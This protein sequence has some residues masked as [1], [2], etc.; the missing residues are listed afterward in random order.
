[1]T[2]VRLVTVAS[3]T[4]T[5]AS[6]SGS[7]VYL[8][9]SDVVKS[10]LLEAT[11]SQLVTLSGPRDW[12]PLSSSTSPTLT[13]AIRIAALCN[14]ARFQSKAA[15]RR[16]SRDTTASEPIDGPATATT[17]SLDEE[18]ALEAEEKR[19]IVGGNGIDKALLAWAATHGDPATTRAQHVQL[20]DVPFSSA[21]KISAGVWESDTS[22]FVAVK[23]APEF[24]LDRCASALD[25]NGNVVPMTSQ[26]FASITAAID[27]LSRKGQRIIALGE[28]PLSYDAD[29]STTASFPRG[30]HF[31][32]EPVSDMPL[33]C[34][35]ELALSDCH[36]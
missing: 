9:T 34:G 26:L 23:G 27:A 31:S 36:R 22:R 33:A 6:Q 5:G 3:S 24:V 12:I 14:P 18:A 25:A 21:T 10:P 30:F 28:R 15:S 19:I 13:T 16:G 32:V 17:A 35:S 11:A 8:G 2:V 29:T 4:Y 7:D 20:A 1:M